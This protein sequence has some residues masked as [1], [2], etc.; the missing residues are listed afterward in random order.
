VEVK[1]IWVSRSDGSV[2]I[3]GLPYTRNRNLQGCLEFQK[4]EVSQVLEIDSDDKRPNEAQALIEISPQQILQVRALNKTNS[5]Y[6]DCRYGN[7]P[8]WLT[9][10]PKEQEEQGPFT[11]RWKLYVEYRDARARQDN[12]K[13]YVTKAHL[14]MTQAEA[15]EAFRVSDQEVKRKWRGRTHRGGSHKPSTAREDQQYTFGDTFCS[16]GGASRG[17]VLAGLKVS[18]RQLEARVLR[19]Y[20]TCWQLVFGVDHWPVACAT[21]RRNF[22]G[23]RMFEQHITDW[24]LNNRE[25]DRRSH[26]IDILH[27]S[28]PC[29][30]FSTLA[31]PHAAH[32]NMNHEAR[33]VLLACTHVIDKIRPRL[34]T[35]EQTFG[36]MQ[37][38]HTEYLNSL[39]QGFTRLGYSVRW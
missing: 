29:Q 14:R 34:F 8:Q 24:I 11:C 28:P 18:L 25:I 6:P 37:A 7:D 9:R 33:A 30:P 23:A 20:L 2:I 21:W 35:L 22:P 3:R 31:Y 1:S 38:A 39:I 16:A 17:A 13:V 32:G 15:D 12:N 4:N 5:K 27:L 19:A 10:T 26:S 36:L